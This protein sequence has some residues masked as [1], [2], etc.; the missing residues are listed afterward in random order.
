MTEVGGPLVIGYWLLVIGYWLLVVS[1]RSRR[2][3]SV[4]ATGGKANLSAGAMG[5]A[6]ARV[7]V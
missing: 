3:E 6:Q 4:G 5:G 2:R 1:W 7:K